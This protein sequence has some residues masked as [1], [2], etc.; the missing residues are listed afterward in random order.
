MPQCS[1]ADWHAVLTVAALW[2]KC[3]VDPSMLAVLCGVCEF[4]VSTYTN[5]STVHMPMVVTHTCRAMPCKHASM[6]L[7]HARQSNL[8]QP[9]GLHLES[10]L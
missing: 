5:G 10:T 6:D 7:L 1:S 9:T 3:R 2:L 8:L 4:S